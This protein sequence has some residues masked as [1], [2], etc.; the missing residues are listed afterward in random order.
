MELKWKKYEG[1]KSDIE[2]REYRYFAVLRGHG[3][4]D[5]E[6]NYFPMVDNDDIL[7]WLPL[8]EPPGRKLTEEKMR[9]LIEIMRT[10]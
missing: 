10:V 3:M 5:V 1:E 8:P 4:I 7:Y 9:E 6:C 2:M